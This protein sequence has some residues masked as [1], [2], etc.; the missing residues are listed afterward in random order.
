MFLIARAYRLIDGVALSATLMEDDLESGRLVPTRT[1]TSVTAPQAGEV[2][3]AELAG[4]LA[5]LLQEW[6][7]VELGL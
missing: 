3:L 1:I 6:S 2:T 5:R 7:W 4:E